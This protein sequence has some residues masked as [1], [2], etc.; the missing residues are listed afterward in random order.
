M[1]LLTLVHSIMTFQV[2]C[3]SENFWPFVSDQSWLHPM[4]AES[5]HTAEKAALAEN[6]MVG[7]VWVEQNL[8]VHNLSFQFQMLLSSD[9]NLKKYYKG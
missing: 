9:D 1:L 4:L 5:I 8:L 6:M 7:R 3:S 2:E